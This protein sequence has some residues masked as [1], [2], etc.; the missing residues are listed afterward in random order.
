[1]E[2]LDG[3]GQLGEPISAESRV[4]S[5]CGPAEGSV[6]GSAEGWLSPQNAEARCMLFA[7]VPIWHA[8]VGRD[9]H[10]IL[11]FSGCGLQWPVRTPS[12]PG[13]TEAE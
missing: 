2:N 13:G 4:R 7:A 10:A 9:T 11:G 1:M 6:A 12:G 5:A 8:H 3:N